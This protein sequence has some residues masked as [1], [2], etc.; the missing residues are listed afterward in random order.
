[1]TPINQS[2][3][4]TWL[5]ALLNLEGGATPFPW[6]EALFERLQNG[7]IVSSLDIP[8]GLG[9]TSVIALWL[10][11]LACGAPLPRRLVYVVDRR[12]VVD[13][14]TEVAD[15]MKTCVDNDSS[16]KQALKLERSLPVSTLR[17]QHADNREWLEDPSCPAI[18]VGTVDMV[19]SRLLFEG[20]GVSRKMR[21]YHA[22]LL[23][24]D[25]LLVLDEAH[26]VPPF[27]R[28]V[29]AVA[30]GAPLFGP[31]NANLRPLIPLFRVMSLSATGRGNGG[32][33]F[34]LTP[35]DLE[36]NEVTRQRLHAS[37]RLTLLSLNEK[38][39]LATELAKQAWALSDSGKLPIRCLVFS[40]ERKV[41]QDAEGE[42]AKL[43]KA[44]KVDVQTDLFV[45]GRRVYERADAADRLKE[46][47]FIAGT[48]ERP[49]LPVF[50]F[51]TS[52]A[53]VGVD[54]DADHMVC[55]LVPW[56]RMVQRLGRVN[57]RGD[58]KAEVVVL[59]AP[60]KGDDAP[61][62]L[63]AVTKLLGELPRVSPDAFDASPGAIVALKKRANTDEQLAQLITDA[64]TP[65]PLHPPLTRPLLDAW[66]MT[67]LDEHTGRPDVEPWLRGW[68]VNEEPQTTVVWREILPVTPNG[69]LLAEA[70]VEA[71]LTAAPPQLLES[72]E[73]ET[74]EVVPWFKK[75]LDALRAS[76]EPDAQL[77]PHHVVALV[78]DRKG[79]ARPIR[80][81]E[82]DDDKRNKLEDRLKHV[83]L[84][85]DVRLGGLDK[86]LL[87]PNAA[88]ASEVASLVNDARVPFRISLGQGT[89]EPTAPPKLRRESVITTHH[90]ADGE[91][92]WIYIDTWVT[93]APET[94]DGRSV[95]PK[96][97]QEL[98]KHQSWAGTEAERIAERLK[99][100]DNYKQMLKTSARL[101]DEGKR[102]ARW[103][104]AFGGKP[105]KVLAKS[106]TR[107][108]QK[109][110]GGYRH[111]FGSLPY[112][113]A[114]AEF[115][116]LGE[117]EREL[118]LHLIAAHHGRARPTIPIDGAEDPPSKLEERAREVAL[119]FAR[120]NKIWGPWGL[121]WWEALLRA[122]D[123]RAS[124]RNDEEGETN[125]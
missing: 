71:Y 9:K 107:P 111:E 87:N 5:S 99:L 60:A 94:E 123:A 83:T 53:E 39:S 103:Q 76:K 65:A 46:L 8:T 90:S 97:E 36:E 121:A 27:E 108:N 41:A 102:A 32:E 112:A 119:R 64:S 78:I 96:H 67:S 48:K 114:D 28:L 4:A 125:G 29:S 12:A 16:L 73:I 52:A 86:G 75:R 79:K 14:A 22:G 62:R 34:G 51:A 70:D 43:A 122:A 44:Q 98:S 72:L 6:Q 110:L 117:L 17:G 7:D 42:L 63:D 69:Q 68:D 26:L 57:R 85:V 18:I 93:E 80:L 95:S 40:N 118:C 1:M 25:T 89:L 11:A 10:T 74:R 35:K 56:E 66:A 37:K 33:V 54:L 30:A 91:D 58:G 49:P 59:A 15:H 120:L 106:T 38:A 55:D 77:S 109:I 50:L 116:A 2:Q 24:V 61:K 100:P 84:L 19:G 21:P 92:G 88:N 113:Q 47:G 115:A 13:Q 3:V 81:S 101:H 45:G 124:R 82:T 105:G 23:G 31:K 20:Y 104:R